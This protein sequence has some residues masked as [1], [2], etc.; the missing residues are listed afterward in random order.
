M[1]AYRKYDMVLPEEC[2]Q[3]SELSGEEQREGHPQ[4][5]VSE[6]DNQGHG[7]LSKACTQGFDD[8]SDSGVATFDEGFGF[9]VLDGE[10]LVGCVFAVTGVAELRM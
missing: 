2:S 3:R 5:Q 6:A 9:F 4:K 1:K 7:R 8:G 10:G